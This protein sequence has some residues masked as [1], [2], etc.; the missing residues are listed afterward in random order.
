MLRL[1][2]FSRTFAEVPQELTPYCYIE[3]N[4]FSI[5]ALPIMLSYKLVVTTCRAAAMLI[6][7]RLTNRDLVTL[8]SNVA[9]ILNPTSDTKRSV[10][11]HWTALFVD[12]AAQATEPEILVPL[13]VITPP[14][15]LTHH[16]DP[17]FVMAGDQYQ[18]GPR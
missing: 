14:V 15:R 4:T 5:P 2:E 10:P 1:N 18:L 6:E 16:P 3:E 7:A 11:L 13:T 9:K 8:Q 17:I 12:E